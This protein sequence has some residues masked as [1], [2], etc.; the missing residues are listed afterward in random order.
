LRQRPSGTPTAAIRHCDSTRLPLRQRTSPRSGGVP[1][2]HVVVSTHG[3][4]HLVGAGRSTVVGRA[5]LAVIRRPLWLRAGRRAISDS[6]HASGWWS[7]TRRSQARQRRRSA[8][9]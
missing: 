6:G 4:V 8:G 9:G 3:S 7:P 5:G 2:S 1:G